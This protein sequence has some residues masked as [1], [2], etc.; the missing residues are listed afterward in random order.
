MLKNLDDAIIRQLFDNYDSKSIADLDEFK[1]DIM[2]FVYVYRLLDR[3]KTS[4]VLNLNL[5]L[6]H[7][8]ILYNCF[9][10]IVTKILL[11]N[12]DELINEVSTLLYYIDRL[13]EEFE[14]NVIPS[15][16][17]E[18]DTLVRLKSEEY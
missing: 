14:K 18:L 8:V 10:Y 17:S 7:V 2:R 4:G 1:E 13:P 15:M 3:Y 6:N 12:S 16:I 11:D 5:L 9:G